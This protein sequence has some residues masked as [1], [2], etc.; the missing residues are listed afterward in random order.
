MIQEI[1]LENLYHKEK[2]YLLELKIEDPIL[3]AT[4]YEYKNGE[5]SKKYGSDTILELMVDA[6][7][8]IF[9]N[10]AEQSKSEVCSKN[11]ESSVDQEKGIIKAP[12]AK[13][14]RK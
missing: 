2:D 1:E 5:D 12:L 4:M 3:A 8:D 13:E 9:T 6:Y 7:F 10:H 14:K 11:I